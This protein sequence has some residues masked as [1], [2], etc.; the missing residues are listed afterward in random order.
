MAARTFTTATNAFMR[1]SKG[2]LTAE[3]APAVTTLKV[4]ASQLDR[5]VSAALVA[6]YGLTYRSLLKEKPTA[7]AGQGDELAAALASAGA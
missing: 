4:L 5:E 3:H 6:Q 1:A 2:W 7:P